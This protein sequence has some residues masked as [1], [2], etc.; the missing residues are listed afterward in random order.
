MARLVF[1]LGGARS[2]KSW[3]AQQLAERV[4]GGDV[5]F[6]ATADAGDAEMA[7][8]IE[9]HRHSRRAD[10]CTLERT[11]NVAAALDPAALASPFPVQHQVVLIDCLT[12][13]VSNLLL[14][15]GSPPDPDEA[16]RAVDGEINALLASLERRPGTAIVV[17][18]EVGMGLVPPSALGRL[19]RDLLGWANQAVA[20]RAD[21]VYLLVAGMAID[22][23]PLSV[24]LDQAAVACR[25][26]TG[27]PDHRSDRDCRGET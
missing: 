18:G 22:V 17:S 15:C 4:G 25:P 27:V 6:V 16:R 19:F 2:G 20:A 21:T 13:L 3:F 1:I 10:W 5:L 26:P 7:R 14:A 11:S 9:R 8:R 23:R 24:S 12:L